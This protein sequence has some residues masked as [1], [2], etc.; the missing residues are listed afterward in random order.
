MEKIPNPCHPPHPPTAA[1]MSR[2]DPSA[3]LCLFGTLGA[4]LLTG[5]VIS[6]GIWPGWLSLNNVLLPVPCNVTDYGTNGETFSQCSCVTVKVFDLEG[7]Q[8]PA[9][10]NGIYPGNTLGWVEDQQATNG[11]ATC[12]LNVCSSTLSGQKSPYYVGDSDS[13]CTLILQHSYNAVYLNYTYAWEV[14]WFW[15]ASFVGG[16]ACIG[17]IVVTVL[18]AR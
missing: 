7:P 1:V 8:L 4:F 9:Y 3:L 16:L 6:F 18:L 17:G 11:T 10:V 5:S 14:F 13:R 15:L 2:C 12:Y